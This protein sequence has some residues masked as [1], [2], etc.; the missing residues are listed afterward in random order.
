MST[1]LGMR[2]ILLELTGAGSEDFELSRRRARDIEE[3][4]V[5]E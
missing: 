2:M 1:V 4:E 5:R 3:D